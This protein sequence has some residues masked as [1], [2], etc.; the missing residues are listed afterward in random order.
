[1]PRTVPVDKKED[2]V[3]VDESGVD[4]HLHRR[5]ARSVKG[6]KVFGFVAGK[7]FQRTNIGARY[8]DGK[9]IAECVYNCYRMCL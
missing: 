9:T 3:C 5:N 2:I 7:K 1:M 8:A 6:K 4:R